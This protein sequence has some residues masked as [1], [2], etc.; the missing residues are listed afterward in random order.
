MILTLKM[1]EVFSEENI[2]VN[3]FLIPGIKQSKESGKKFRGWQW[4][5]I[6]AIMQPF[7]RTPARM[8]ETYYTICTSVEFRDV[9]GQLV[10]IHNQVMGMA[11]IVQGVEYKAN[12]KELWHMTEVPAYAVRRENIENTWR[13][14]TDLTSGYL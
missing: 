5:L 6:A 12:P 10:N 9:S 3:V 11:D 13:I 7:L 4:R 14:A 8:A 1:A 2:S